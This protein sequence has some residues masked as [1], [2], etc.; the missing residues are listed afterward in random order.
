MSFYFTLDWRACLIYLQCTGPQI[1]PPFTFSSLTVSCT[2][3]LH[4]L[5]LC[6]PSWCV[7]GSLGSEKY[8]ILLTQSWGLASDA[9]NAIPLY[10]VWILCTIA[11]SRL[12]LNLQSHNTDTVEDGK[13]GGIRLVETPSTCPGRS[14]S[15]TVV[16]SHLDVSMVDSSHDIEKGDEGKQLSHRKS[17]SRDEWSWHPNFPYLHHDQNHDGAGSIFT[18]P[19]A[20]SSLIHPSIRTIRSSERRR[21]RKY[22]PRSARSGR[23]RVGPGGDTT[24][25][26]A[27]YDEGFTTGSG[28]VT[29]G[30]EWSEV[31]TDSQERRRT[32]NLTRT[33]TNFKRDITKPIALTFDLSQRREH[34]TGP[35][36]TA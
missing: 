20:S 33:T 30:S 10:T 4:S 5:P 15:F 12:L 23:L 24:D 32:P 36:S 35:G 7:E 26:H 1:R 9:Y 11:M 14:S 3:P 16:N 31:P 22:K 29:S 6:F 19:Y 8:L 25:P 27:S 34:E 13:L 2:T 17:N 28:G 21:P 18:A